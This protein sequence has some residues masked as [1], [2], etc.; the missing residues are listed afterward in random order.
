VIPDLSAFPASWLADAELSLTI[1][2][3]ERVGLSF[4]STDA[5]AYAA[6]C[7]QLGVAR[8]DEERLRARF[9]LAP[10]HWV[11]LHFVAGARTGSSQYL[12]I[13]ER[14]VYPITTLRLFARHHA[15]VASSTGGRAHAVSRLEPMLAPALERE[16]TAWIVTLKR[17]RAC[18]PRISFRLARDVFPTLMKSVVAAEGL[19]RERADR[20]LEW[21]RRLEAGDALWITVDPLRGEMSCVDF[22]SCAP[23]S[24]PAGWRAATH[25]IETPPPRYLKCRLRAGSADPEWVVY[26]GAAG[27]GPAAR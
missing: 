20:Y 7:D 18:E 23:G 16:D 13:H 27:F 14:N 3:P 10:R 11:K 17:E 2:R 26:L 9:D 8:D 25:G 4:F 12:P 1:D 21:N 5:A 19:D 24:L 22:E 15:G 6:F